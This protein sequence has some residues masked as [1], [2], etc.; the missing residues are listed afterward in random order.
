MRD[1]YINVVVFGYG[2]KGA[3]RFRIRKRFLKGFLLGTGVSLVLLASF[4]AFTFYQNQTLKTKLSRLKEREEELKV[5]LAKAERGNSYLEQLKAKVEEFEGKLVTIDKFLRKKGIREVPGG[6]GGARNKIDILDVNYVDF[7]KS[8][9]VRFQK[10]ISSIPLGPPV[11]G[12]ITSDFGYRRDPFDERYEFHDG[13][14]IKAPW[15]APVR[16]TADG[17][18]IYAG[19]KTDYG[20]TVIIRH[21][22]GFMTLYAHLSEIEV[23]PGMWVKS[24]QVIGY[25]GSTGR[26]T[27]PH[28]HYEVW[29]YSRKQDPVEYMYVRW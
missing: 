4:S 7:L 28:V 8:E 9:A 3:K 15:G 13:V 24:G 29:R 18:V 27:G 21:A 26:S 1:D 11:W 12:G 5:L 22:Y 2:G 16:A 10:Y 19:W 6:I 20:K 23:K 25:V 17:K 14:D